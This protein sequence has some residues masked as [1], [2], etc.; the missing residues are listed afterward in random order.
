MSRSELQFISKINGIKANGKNSEILERLI[1]REQSLVVVS[2]MPTSD[3]KAMNKQRVMEEK[4]RELLQQQALHAEQTAKVAENDLVAALEAL[5]EAKRRHEEALALQQEVE[6]R[7]QRC[8]EEIKAV[9]NYRKRRETEVQHTQAVAKRKRD[10]IE[11]N[12]HRLILTHSTQ[13]QY[14]HQSYPTEPR[15]ISEWTK[16]VQDVFQGTQQLINRVAENVK[17]VE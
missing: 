7:I 15:T 5:K 10:A 14:N 4:K 13:Q 2:M 9:D 3:N 11:Q 8:K 12:N 1:E 6:I 17:N 16:T